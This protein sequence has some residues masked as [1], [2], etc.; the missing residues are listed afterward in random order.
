MNARGGRK[1]IGSLL[2]GALLS[3]VGCAQPVAP[4]NAW[5]ERD[6]PVSKAAGPRSGVLLFDRVASDRYSPEDFAWRSGWPCVRSGVSGGEIIW[7][8]ERFHDRE[9]WPFT[10]Y[11]WA[12][13]RFDT[14]RTGV[15]FR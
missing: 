5:E 14:R 9:G 7:Y 13:R 2:A 10:R 11:H 8:E 12:Y 4:V 3:L 1:L 6:H 15:I